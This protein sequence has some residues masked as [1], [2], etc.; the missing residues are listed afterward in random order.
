MPCSDLG[1]R[2]DPLRVGR[3]P[4]PGRQ[5]RQAP[6]LFGVFLLRLWVWLVW[7]FSVA[8]LHSGDL[9]LFFSPFPPP[10]LAGYVQNGFMAQLKAPA[11]ILGRDQRRLPGLRGSVGRSEQRPEASRVLPQLGRP[12]GAR[13]R[14]FFSRTHGRKPAAAADRP[15]GRGRAAGPARL[16]PWCCTDLRPHRYRGASAPSRRW[17]GLAAR[18]RRAWPRR[19]A[20]RAAS[21]EPG[22][23]AAPE[24]LSVI[25]LY[26]VR[27]LPLFYVLHV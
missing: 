2:L 13:N 8:I 27:R 6:G 3:A 14:P 20:G 10:V 15:T 9:G 23:R 19:R 16:W 21:G 17:H 1:S 22:H 25:A 5:L 24:L 7:I 11:S 4:A 18:S 26:R 12:R